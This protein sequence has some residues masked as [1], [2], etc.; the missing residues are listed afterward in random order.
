[1]PGTSQRGGPHS[2]WVLPPCEVLAVV[3]PGFWFRGDKIKRQH[4]NTTQKIE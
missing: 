3:E 2:V 1:M 4:L